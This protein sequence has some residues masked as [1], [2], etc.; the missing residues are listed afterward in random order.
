M[1][2]NVKQARRPRP[3]L[4]YDSGLK[5]DTNSFYGSSYS[6]IVDD[7]VRNK[8]VSFDT[9]EKEYCKLLF[10]FD[11]RSGIDEDYAKQ[12][13]E[14]IWENPD[15]YRKLFDAS[16]IK[17]DSAIRK[18]YNELT[19]KTLDYKSINLD[20]IL[21]KPA[22]EDQILLCHEYI[23]NA[24]AEIHSK[25]L[26]KYLDGL[27]KYTPAKLATIGAFKPDNLEMAE[28]FV[29]FGKEKPRYRK[30]INRDF[31]VKIDDGNLKNDDDYITL[32]KMLKE[33]PE[34]DDYSLMRLEDL[35][36]I[37]KIE[38][39]SGYIGRVYVGDEKAL[40][41]R[42]TAFDLWTQNGGVTEKKAKRYLNDEYHFYDHIPAGL[43]MSREEFLNIIKAAEKKD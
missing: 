25:L 38:G 19:G 2:A 40:E 3:K 18:S 37:K 11:L 23:E 12:L 9:D 24:P 17:L 21:A 36:Q 26:G 10:K 42:R 4:L 35:F 31:I 1:A 32:L 15:V 5:L 20:T 6:N 22:S 41:F 39:A 14:H 16:P 30:F 43:K 28:Q 33:N 8:K 34:F 29:K 27:K 13:L 7:F